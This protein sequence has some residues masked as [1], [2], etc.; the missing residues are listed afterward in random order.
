MLVSRRGIMGLVAALGLAGLPWPALAQERRVRR[1]IASLSGRDDDLA[2]LAEAL[3]V[4]ESRSG[5]LS[6]EAQRAFHADYGRHGNWLF[7][8]WHRAELLLFEAVVAAVTGHSRFALPYW[9]YQAT[10]RLPSYFSD[11][12][13]PFYREDRAPADTDYREARWAGERRFAD[14][15]RD[16]F[17]TFVGTPRAAGAVEAFG[18]NKVHVLAGGAMGSI[19]TAPLDPLFYL[20][21]CNVDRVWMTWQRRQ[22]QPPPRAWLSA[23][24]P[25]KTSPEGG[26][27]AARVST[28][29]DPAALS[30]DY[31]EPYA[32][33]FFNVPD[34]PPTGKTRR[35]IVGEKRFRGSARREG[36]SRDLRVRLD[37]EALAAI[38]ADRDDLLRI[39]GTGTVSY[40]ET[41]LAGRVVRVAAAAAGDAPPIPLSASPAFLNLQ[42]GGHRHGGAGVAHRFRF[43]DNIV[44][45][46][47]RSEGSVALISSTETIRAAERP[48]PRA[49]ALEYELKLTTT[50]WV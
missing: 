4:M 14:L 2:A 50:R 29:A 41:N 13:H 1:S 49:I 10:P 24:M 12:A 25:V 48:A 15:S 22:V 21:H 6:L 44:N 34:T 40:A 3:R 8:P 31:D 23:R 45:L 7:F 11:P 26:V 43:G 39:E 37:E 32:F 33:P 18:H 19:G 36:R 27:E 30:Y 16:S 42:G 9:D 20:H 35:E 28:V 5:A 46:V 38:R 47:G 17:D